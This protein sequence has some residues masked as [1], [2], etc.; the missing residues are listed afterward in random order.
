MNKLLNVFLLSLFVAGCT[1]PPLEPAESGDQLD[2]VG[3]EAAADSQADIADIDELS[4][5]LENSD[6][7]NIEIDADY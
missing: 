1:A 5:E 7:E 6:I 2:A 4:E 3:Q